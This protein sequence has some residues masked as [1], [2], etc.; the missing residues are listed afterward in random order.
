MT[1]YLAEN[2]RLRQLSRRYADGQLSLEDYRTARR[3]IIEALEAGEV[4]SQQ[5]VPPVPAPRREPDMDS[6]DIR[7]PDDSEV[8]YK[9]MP[10]HALS[11]EPVPASAGAPAAPG[12][13]AGWDSHTRILAAVLGFSL[14]LAV[15]ALVYVFAL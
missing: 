8:F 7:L 5:T 15:S 9:T 4:Q 14:L 12:E 3:E 2:A 1:E 13:Q 10:P 6:T 11:S